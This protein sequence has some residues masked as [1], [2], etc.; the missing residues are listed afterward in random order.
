MMRARDAAKLL[1][2]FG[3]GTRLRIIF[4]LAR[5]ELCVGSLARVLKSPRKRVS[6]H[7]QYLSARGVVESETVRGRAVYRLQ[8]D[9]GALQRAV[10]TTVQACRGLISEVRDDEARAAREGRERG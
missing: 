9:C 1:R 7:L 5:H 3:D 8:P 4:I 6:R 2:A 10:L